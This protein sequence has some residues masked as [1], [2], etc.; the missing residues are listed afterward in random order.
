MSYVL[1]SFTNQ[2]YENESTLWTV[3]D[4]KMY[5]CLRGIPTEGLLDELNYYYRRDYLQTRS[6][7]KWQDCLCV[8]LLKERNSLRSAISISGYS[9]EEN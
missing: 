6:S 5:L 7:A 8:V 2:S 9:R 4:A 1:N 3:S